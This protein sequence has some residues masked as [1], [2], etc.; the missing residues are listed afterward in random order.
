MNSSF[1]SEY[2]MLESPASMTVVIP[3]TDASL[4]EALIII[5]SQVSKHTLVVYMYILIL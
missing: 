5:M 4:F 1:V 3:M 2:N